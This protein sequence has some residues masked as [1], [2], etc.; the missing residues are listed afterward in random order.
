MLESI[1]QDIETRFGLL[2]RHEQR[3]DQMQIEVD[4]EQ[5]VQLLAWLQGGTGYVQ[6][7]HMSAVDWLEDQRFQLTYMMTDPKVRHMLMI[8]VQI[9]REKAQMDS[10][11]HLWPQ[12]VT[13]EQEINEMFG[14]EFLGSPR[15]GVPFI[16]ED[17]QDMPPMRRDFDT[18]A[19]VEKNHP[20]RPGRKHIVTRQYVGE[21]HGEKSML[22]LRDDKAAAKV[23]QGKEQA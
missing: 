16:L 14:I 2:T 3:P 8:S 13:Y 23:R 5:L 6:L 19:Y 22:N 17:W 1:L 20:M 21:K 10:V 7:T 18:R 12:A 11:A 9:D 4:P 15:M